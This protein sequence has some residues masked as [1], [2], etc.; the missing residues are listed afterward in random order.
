MEIVTLAIFCTS[1]I[2]K[3]VLMMMMTAATA[4]TTAS[5][6][7]SGLVRK[8]ELQTETRLPKCG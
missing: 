4:G 2:I 5:T 6:T 7:T 1:K 8:H 3:K